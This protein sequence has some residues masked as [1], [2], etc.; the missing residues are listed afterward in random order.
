MPARHLVSI[1][2]KYT[3]S[4]NGALDASISYYKLLEEE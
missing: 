2:P 1:I 3:R 4:S